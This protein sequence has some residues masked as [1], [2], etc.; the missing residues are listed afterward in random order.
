MKPMHFFA[1]RG[2]GAGGGGQH[3]NAVVLIP[4]TLIPQRV[5]QGVKRDFS[6]TFH[7]MVPWFFFGGPKRSRITLPHSLH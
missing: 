6:G 5:T 4:P 1:R 2:R 7:F 3:R